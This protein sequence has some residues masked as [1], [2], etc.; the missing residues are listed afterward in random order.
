MIET[1]EGEPRRKTTQGRVRT[2]FPR[3]KNNNIYNES[4]NRQQKKQYSHVEKEKIKERTKKKVKKQTRVA[5]ITIPFTVSLLST[6]T[7]S[8]VRFSALIS[9]LPSL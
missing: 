2:P 8:L 7:H 9:T 1:N 4:A 6:T 3:A 5:Y